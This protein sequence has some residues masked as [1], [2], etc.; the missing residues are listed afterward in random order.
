M[1]IVID[2]S[3]GDRLIDGAGTSHQTW[4]AWSGWH[5]LPPLN[6]MQDFPAGQRV[7]IVAPHPDDEILGCAGLIQ[8]LD[9]L[10]RDMLLLAVTNGTHSHPQSSL[11][12]PQ[13]LDRLRPE[14]SAAALRCLKLGRLPER[15]ELNLTDGRVSRQQAQLYA[16]LSALIRPDDILV[17]TFAQDGHPDHESVGRTVRYLAKNLGLSCYQMLIWAWHWASPDDRRIP[18]QAAYKLALSG[19]QREAK[20]Q[21]L[22]CFKSQLEADASTGQPPVLSA[23]T[24][25]RSLMPY[26]VY[27]DAQ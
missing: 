5:P 16:A 27:I 13:Q 11:Y 26:E 1:G 4:Q 10:Q 25:A 18:W 21:A 2:H 9:Q 3:V 14:E 20:R 7:V 6:L 24:L 12:S 23:Q 17:C 8:Q 19:P 15:I 22:S